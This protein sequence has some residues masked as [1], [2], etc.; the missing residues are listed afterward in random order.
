MQA[1]LL[2]G[3]F[4]HLPAINLHSGVDS[5]PPAPRRLLSCE[6][7]V[8][9][10]IWTE[11][12]DR[13]DLSPTQRHI[14]GSLWTHFLQEAQRG[15]VAVGSNATQNGQPAEALVNVKSPARPQILAQSTGF[16]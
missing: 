9:Q 16:L 4:Y 14:P 2:A 10:V 1:F 8:F 5:G 13:E 12:S 6:N 11:A 7:S 15:T 3:C